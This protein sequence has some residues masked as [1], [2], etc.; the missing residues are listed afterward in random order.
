MS[1]M[2]NMRMYNNRVF[3]AILLF[4]EVSVTITFR[5]KIYK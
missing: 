4:A 5:V 1:S 2:K 3:L